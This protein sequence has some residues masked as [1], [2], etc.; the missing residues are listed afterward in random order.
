MTICLVHRMARGCLGRTWFYIDD[1]WASDDTLG[2][3]D[4]GRPLALDNIVDATYEII[5]YIPNGA[6]F[7][8]LQCNQ[9]EYFHSRLYNDIASRAPGIWNKS[10]SKQS[11]AMSALSAAAPPGANAKRP[12]ERAAV[13][14]S[15]K[16]R[17]SALYLQPHTPLLPPKCS[18]AAPFLPSPGALSP[19]ARSCPLAA[20]SAA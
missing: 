6:Y 3:E 17:P 9:T 18:P 10:K 11:P 13:A 1:I 14:A 12:Q 19:R 2:W 20:S 7:H 5:V 15:R 16:L 8:L 4:N